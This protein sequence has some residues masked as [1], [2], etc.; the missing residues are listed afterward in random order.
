MLVATSAFAGLLP[1]LLVLGCPLMMIF[2]LRGMR[3]GGDPSPPAE[4]PAADETD[5][6]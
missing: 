3:H 4:P 1:L 2:M 5:T 6:L